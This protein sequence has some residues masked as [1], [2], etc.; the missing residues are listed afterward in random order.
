MV[1]IK[2]LYAVAMIIFTYRLLNCKR[3]TDP[4]GNIEFISV[5]EA[6]EEM[7]RTKEQLSS[8]EEMITDITICSPDDHNKY[9]R[10]EWANTLGE[11]FKYDLFIDGNGTVSDELLKIAYAERSRLRTLLRQQI[12]NL[13]DRCNE[14]CNENYAFS[15]GEGLDDK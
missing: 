10:C 13:N 9:I 11:C 2:V 15:L 14:N 6:I 5:S 3:C 4:E 7:N 1:F 12:R 8:I